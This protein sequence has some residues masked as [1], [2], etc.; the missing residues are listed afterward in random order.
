MLAH[1]ATFSAPLRRRTPSRVCSSL[2]LLVGEPT[3]P[4]PSVGSVPAAACF[5]GRPPPFPCLSRQP[6][7]SLA[8][9]QPPR[10]LE[11]VCSSHRGQAGVR[12][13]S[14]HGLTGAPI[15]NGCRPFP[16]WC[17]DP[18]THSP[19]SSDPSTTRQPLL[20][21]VHGQRRHNPCPLSRPPPP[22]SCRRLAAVCASSRFSRHRRH[23]PSSS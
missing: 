4:F 23:R 15:P 6:L 3:P 11:P 20:R 1:R 21:R 19:W 12:A 22:C 18:L 13:G 5:V 17:G 7:C 8:P 10:P 2:P 16:H 14:R 9:R